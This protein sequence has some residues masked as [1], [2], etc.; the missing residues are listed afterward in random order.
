MRENMWVLFFWSW[1]T[2]FNMMTSSCIHLTSNSMFEVTYGLVI[3]IVYLYHNFLI[4]PS[5]VGH[6]GGFQSLTSTNSGW[7]NI[8]EQVNY[9]TSPFSFLVLFFSLFFLVNL[10]L[11]IS[12]ISKVIV[13][14]IGLFYFILVSS[15]FGSTVIFIIS[16]LFLISGLFC[17]FLV[18]W[19]V[20]LGYL[21]EIFLL[22]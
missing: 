19:G 20:K 2:S 4:H 22:S 16:F 7:M 11:S 1:L 10:N 6:L 5:V 21:L 3:S 14:F 13:S 17:S 9:S 15:S 8:G 12:F 18:F